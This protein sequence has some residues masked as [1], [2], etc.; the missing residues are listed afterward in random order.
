M[1]EKENRAMRKSAMIIHEELQGSLLHVLPKMYHGEFSIH[2][3]NDYVK[4]I[5]QVVKQK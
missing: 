1:G 4:W 2:Y 5:L 3:V